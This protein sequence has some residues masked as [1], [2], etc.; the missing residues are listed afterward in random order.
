MATTRVLIASL[1]FVVR[2]SRQVFCPISAGIGM[3]NFF[4]NGIHCLLNRCLDIEKREGELLLVNSGKNSVFLHLVKSSFRL[5]P[6]FKNHLVSY[7]FVLVSPPRTI[8]CK[9]C[10]VQDHTCGLPHCDSLYEVARD[11]L[12]ITCFDVSGI[13]LQLIK[14]QLRVKVRSASTQG[15]HPTNTAT[16]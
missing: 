11:N 10:R 15:T 14:L 1:M 5:S 13:L 6:G 4:L 9:G 2:S 12:P 8:H 7:A 16:L 3:G